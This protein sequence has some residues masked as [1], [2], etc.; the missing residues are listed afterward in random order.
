M[1]ATP[2]APGAERQIA[3][4]DHDLATFGY[5]QELV[6]SLGAFSAFAIGFAFI[7]ILTGAFQLFGF[8]YGNGGPAMWWVWVIAVGGQLL[9]AL[10]FAELAVRYPLAGSVYNWSKQLTRPFTSWISGVSLA[11]ALTVSTA[12]VALAWQFVLPAIWSGFQFVGDGTGTY[13]AAQNAVILGTVMIIGTTA[14]SLAGTRVLSMVNNIGVSVELVAVVLMIV[15]FGL[16]AQRGPAVVM[17]TNGTGDAH[18]TGYLG[19]MLI[20]VL[21][22]LYI[23]WGFDTAGSVSEETVNPRKTNPR[24]VIRALLASGVLGALLILTALMAVGDLKAEELSTGGLAYVVKSVLGDTFGN[25]LLI[26]VAIAIFVCALAN[27]TGAVRMMYAMSRDNALPFGHALSRVS[28]RTEAPVVPILLV[29]VAAIAILVYNIGQP[30]IFVV[31]TSDTVILALIAYVLVVGPFTLNRMRGQW[32]APE[33]G[34]FSLGK[35]G[36]LVSGAAFVWGT[37]MI[38][39]IAWPRQAIYNPAE[40]FHWYLQWGG[41]LFPIGALGLAALL[42]VVYQRNQIGILPE[43]RAAALTKEISEA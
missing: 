21:L 8:A 6:R 31:I 13:D 37:V 33:T 3:A 28:K 27:Q 30:Q 25:L 12:A 7:S 16:H 41:V 23:M 38:I 29:A 4:D 2:L 35:A 20:S 1:E 22:G 11:L 39:N 14:V 40:P 24:A 43:H 36:A 32:Q 5:K 18:S 42:Y 15:F 10:S 17:Q 19:A 9:F 26:C 34:Y